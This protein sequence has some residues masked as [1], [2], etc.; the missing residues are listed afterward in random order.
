[1]DRGITKTFA[2]Q[3]ESH[4]VF[5]RGPYTTHKLCVC[6]CVEKEWLIDKSEF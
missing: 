1:M 5:K 2:N 6:V 4:A 3:E